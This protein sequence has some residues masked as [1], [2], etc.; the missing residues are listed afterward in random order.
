VGP[1]RHPSH[2]SFSPLGESNRVDGASKLSEI[3][4]NQF[5]TPRPCLDLTP[6]SKQFHVAL[7]LGWSLKAKSNVVEGVSSLSCVNASSHSWNVG[8][9]AKVPGSNEF[10]YYSV[11]GVDS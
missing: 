4:L 11:E 10:L 8:A 6:L 7:R 1:R 9:N 3:L 2:I 5:H